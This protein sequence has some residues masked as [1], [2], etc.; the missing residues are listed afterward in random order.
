MRQNTL[1]IQIFQK[2]NK[3]FL[4]LNDSNVKRNKLNR[5]EHVIDQFFLFHFKYNLFIFSNKHVFR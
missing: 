1:I 4:T 2:N 5:I 3:S